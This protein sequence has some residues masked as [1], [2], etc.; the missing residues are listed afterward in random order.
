VVPATRR[1]CRLAGITRSHVNLSVSLRTDW[2][3]TVKFCT[4]LDHLYLD[5]GL[6]LYSS[7]RRTHGDAEL[8]VLCLSDTAGDFLDK[9][10]LP[11]LRVIRLDGI[12][13]RQPG[14]VT[15]CRSRTKAAFAF[16][17]TPYIVLETL[18]HCE[19]EELAIYVDSDMMFFGST[20]D[21]CEEAAGADVLVSPHNFSEH[22]RRQ[23]RFGAFNTG[24]TGFRKT[25]V[26]ER[27]CNWWAERC[28]E[29]CD[30][31]LEGDKFADQKYIE[32]F[33]SVATKT[34]PI[35]HLG[36]NCAPWNASGR[37]FSRHSGKISVDGHPLLLYHFA[38]VKRVRSWSIATGLKRQ[39]VMGAKGIN[40]YV[41]RPYAKALAAV[42]RQYSI[43]T[44]WI[45]GCRSKRHGAKQ[46]QLEKDDHPGAFRL[47]AGIA[48]GK[49][50]V[51][52]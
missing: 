20:K 50:V 9:L 38:K 11:G 19:K 48:T 25:A 35:N 30:D 43:P 40:R 4:K 10:K 32:Q 36:V 23:Q 41:Y 45:S 39:G 21:V 8:H 14:L 16:T 5:R 47:M 49:Y 3:N 6:V 34:A 17:L 1:K 37:R 2:H 42:T 13:A 26:G 29:W 52:V 24:F 15:A 7:L 51:S 31:R 46:R 28:L 27:C 18:K 12:F 33:P 44:A 22:M